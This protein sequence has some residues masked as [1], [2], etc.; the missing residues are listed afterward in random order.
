MQNSSTNSS[1]QILGFSYGTGMLAMMWSPTFYLESSLLWSIINTSCLILSIWFLSTHVRIGFASRLITLWN[2]GG[3]CHYY[4]LTCVVWSFHWLVKLHWKTNFH[5]VMKSFLQR[6][7]VTQNVWTP[8][9][10]IKHKTFLWLWAI[11]NLFQHVL[12][13][14]LL[15]NLFMLVFMLIC[16]LY[17]GYHLERVLCTGAVA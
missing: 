12:W 14:D 5:I 8:L 3:T 4:F 6:M 13:S 7:N 10:V 9:F 17:Y 2:P 11:L 1:G 15:L 16:H